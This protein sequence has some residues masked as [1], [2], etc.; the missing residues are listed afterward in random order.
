LHCEHWHAL[1]LHCAIVNTDI[2]VSALCILRTLTSLCLHVRFLN[3]DIPVSARCV[4]WT[5]SFSVS[6]LCVCEHWHSLCLH[7]APVKFHCREV[8][9]RLRQCA[10]HVYMTRLARTIYIR[11]IYGIL[12]GK[13][14]NIRSYTVY[15]Y[16]SG[17]PYVYMTRLA[18]TVY[19]RCIYGIFGREITEYTVLYGVY[20]RFWPTLISVSMCMRVTTSGTPASPA[21][22]LR[23]HSN[24][25]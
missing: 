21:C 14:P 5:L 18:R 19:I 2:P 10:E 11:C 16:G 13:S 25:S 7:H 8:H 4:L 22:A 23:K 12:T 6:A 3:T 17:Q 1:C 9:C 24:I 20:I 15:L